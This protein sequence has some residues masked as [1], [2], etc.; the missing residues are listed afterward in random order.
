M[1]DYVSEFVL[2]SLELV[3]R[4][5]EMTLAIPTAFTELDMLALRSRITARIKQAD[6]DHDGS[7]VLWIREGEV[8]M[9]T[10]NL[11]AYQGHMACSP[12]TKDAVANWSLHHVFPAPRLLSARA[13]AAAA[14]AAAAVAGSGGGGAAGAAC[15]QQVTVTIDE[16][17]YAAEALR[18]ASM[19]G[20]GNSMQD[21]D[22]DF[23]AGE[24]LLEPGMYG[25]AG[26]A[27]AAGAGAAGAGAG[28]AAAGA[29]C[30]GDSSR[31][32]RPRAAHA[33][34]LQ[35][36]K[37]GPLPPAEPAADARLGG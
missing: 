29:G 30:R 8:G 11:P 14:A 3:E 28:A 9:E 31:A 19:V 20:S 25:A 2:S 37:I 4:P 27:G 10:G 1:A 15:E 35:V 16:L 13:A 23:A 21:M 34:R 22:R 18:L 7:N 33:R 6:T 17:P 12:R 26:A 5:S 36:R 32:Q 24:Q